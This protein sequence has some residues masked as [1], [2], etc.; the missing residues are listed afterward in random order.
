MTLADEVRAL[1]A[2]YDDT[3]SDPTQAQDIAEV[4]L[5]DDLAKITAIRDVVLEPVMELRKNWQH[6]A[7]FGTWDRV[8][9]MKHRVFQLDKA[10][11]INQP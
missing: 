5:R 9:E 6:E 4:D 10:L 8:K 1:L 3:T 2:A 7:T 11:G